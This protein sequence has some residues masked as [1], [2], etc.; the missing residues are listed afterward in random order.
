[1]H[2]L[3]AQ[4][5]FNALK[6]RRPNLPLRNERGLTFFCPKDEQRHTIRDEIKRLFGDEWQRYEPSPHV[7]R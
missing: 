6:L 2:G 7:R 4:Y 3:D 5:V 1:M